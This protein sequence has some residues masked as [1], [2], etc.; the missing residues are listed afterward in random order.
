[1]DWKGVSIAGTTATG[2]V[3]ADIIQVPGPVDQI[4]LS[5]TIAGRDIVATGKDILQPVQIKALNPALMP[6]EIRSKSVG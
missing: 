5:G 3:H 2:S 4:A 1:L 6:D